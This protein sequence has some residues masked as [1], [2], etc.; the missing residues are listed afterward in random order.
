MRT[1][2]TAFSDVN[3]VLMSPIP[4]LDPG[5]RTSKRYWIHVT[6]VDKNLA[7]YAAAW[8]SSYDP[9]SH[10]NELY[11]ILWTNPH[12]LYFHTYKIA[13]PVALDENM[14]NTVL[15]QYTLSKLNT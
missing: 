14:V 5:G 10:L 2:Y 13:T 11:P 3:T 7:A 6:K 8:K 9:D 1:Y 12:L 15:A 4:T